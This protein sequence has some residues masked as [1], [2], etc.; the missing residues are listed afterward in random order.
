ML[1]PECGPEPKNRMSLAILKK[2]TLKKSM[3]ICRLLWKYAG[4]MEMGDGSMMGW[5]FKFTARRF[6][7]ILK[8]IYDESVDCF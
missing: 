7:E 1:K 2:S 3:H 5:G 6:K 4:F 8:D